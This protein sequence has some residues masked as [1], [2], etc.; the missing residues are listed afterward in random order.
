MLR[1]PKDSYRNLMSSDGEAPADCRRTAGFRSVSK[2]LASVGGSRDQMRA[3][4]WMCSRNPRDWNA[5]FN[6]AGLGGAVPRV[7]CRD[8]HRRRRTR[9]RSPRL[10]RIHLS[11]TG[12]NNSGSLDRETDF[13][14]LNPDADL[15]VRLASSMQPGVAKLHSGRSES[16]F[17]TTPK[18]HRSFEEIRNLP[19]LTCRC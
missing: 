3:A 10:E 4:R 1:G 18:S 11:F 2:S 12:S 15:V 14:T 19:S 9:L 8:P 17:A 13:A 5:T 16:Q 7:P 6:L